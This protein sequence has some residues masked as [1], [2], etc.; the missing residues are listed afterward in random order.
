M[1]MISICFSLVPIAGS[2]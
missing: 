1:K 2:G